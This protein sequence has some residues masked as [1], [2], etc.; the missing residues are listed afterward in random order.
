MFRRIIS[1]D[2]GAPWG[3]TGLTSRTWLEVEPAEFAI[4]EL[5]ATQPGLHLHALAAEWPGV[6]YGGDP[7]PH[8]VQWRGELYLEDGHHRAVRA[9]LR[10]ERTIMARHLILRR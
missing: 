5:T 4:A 3:T 9:L 2:D 1:R 6:P 7:Y 10:G 8:V